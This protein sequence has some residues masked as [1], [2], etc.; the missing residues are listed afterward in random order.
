MTDSM[1]LLDTNIQLEVLLGQEKSE[2]VGIFL[3]NIPSFKLFMTDFAFHSLCVILDKLDRLDIL[4]VFISDTF[5]DGN[6]GLIKLDPGDTG[7]IIR[8]IDN[9]NL[10]FDDAYQYTAAHK[11]N[12]ELVSFDSDFDQTPGGKK[13]PAQLS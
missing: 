1:Y 3:G 7:Q 10:D 11:Y 12:L 6:V 4:D 9:Y 13:T 8:A 2:E 5:I